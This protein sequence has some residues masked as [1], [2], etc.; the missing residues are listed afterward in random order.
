MSA[1]VV[2]IHVR[3][4]KQTAKLVFS[5]SSN[6]LENNRKRFSFG[7]FWFKPKIFFVCFEDTLVS[8]NAWLR[9]TVQSQAD[10]I[11]R[12]KKVR[13]SAHRRIINQTMEALTEEHRTVEKSLF[14][15]G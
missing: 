12:R 15:D 14:R 7:S 5:V 4:Q 3:T 11:R 9:R 6:R 10:C 2:S 1:S 13:K 8:E